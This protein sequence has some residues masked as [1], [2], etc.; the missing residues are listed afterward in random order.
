MKITE[1]DIKYAKVRP[2]NDWAKNMLWG[3][4]PFPEGFVPILAITNIGS[5]CWGILMRSR[6][7]RFVI[8]TKG[9]YRTIND[10]FAM[11]LMSKAHVDDTWECGSWGRAREGAGRPKE[12]PDGAKRRSISLTEEEFRFV[13]DWLE[14]CRAKFKG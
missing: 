10:N 5:P 1:T 8:A 2:I 3:P 12:L 7:G 9:A 6:V 13:K 11:E 14:K 4:A